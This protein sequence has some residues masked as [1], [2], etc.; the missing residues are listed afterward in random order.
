MT[1]TIIKL[2][3]AAAAALAAAGAGASGAQAATTCKFA[4]AVL[5]VHMTKDED[6]SVVLGRRGDDRRQ[7]RQ[8]RRSVRRRDAHDRHHRR[9]SG[10]R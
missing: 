3:L 1:R 2:A 4:H 9:G 10:H 5:E 6:A 8:R 7:L